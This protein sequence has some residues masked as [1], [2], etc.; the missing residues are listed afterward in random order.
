M[1][2]RSHRSSA[3]SRD[4]QKTGYPPGQLPG[5]SP[6]VGASCTVCSLTVTVPSRIVALAAETASSCASTARV[7]RQSRPHLGPNRPGDAKPSSVGKKARVI[8]GGPPGDRTLNPRIKSSPGAVCPRPGASRMDRIR[9]ERHGSSCRSVRP[10]SSPSHRVCEG[11]VKAHP[12]L[13][14]CRHAAV[15]CA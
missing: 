7:N 6:H 8:R 1:S 12:T 15:R 13:G 10:G 9:A 14:P 3:M 4:D 5:L 2:G 11:L